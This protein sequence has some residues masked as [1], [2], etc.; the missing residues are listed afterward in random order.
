MKGSCD[1]AARR[2]SD[3]EPYGVYFLRLLDIPTKGTLLVENVP[4]LGKK[5]INKID[6]VS[7]E[8]TYV[9]PAIRGADISRWIV[10]PRFCVVVA[11]K[12]TRKE[13][14]PSEDA[15]RRTSPK[16]FAYFSQFRN[17]LLHR[18]SNIALALA[19]KTSFFAAFG[20][21]IYTFAPVKVV[22]QRMASTMKAAVVTDT[23]DLLP[24][25]VALP[26]ATTSFI[27][28]LSDELEEAY[29][30]CA[31]LNSSPAV[32]FFKSYSSA[33]RGFGSP[34]LI[35][36]LRLPRFD[37]VGVEGHTPA[38][39][40]KKCHE[41][42]STGGSTDTAEKELDDVARTIWSLSKGEMETIW[43]SLAK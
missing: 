37:S 20:V 8:D 27:P 6:P 1:Y 31:L 14:V 12:S 36:Q 40:A 16:T 39:L 7:I 4:E 28:F 29:Y 32:S 18:G 17:V 24:G 9:Y 25:K 33:G 42:S 34:S 19:E 15:L 38:S 2:G 13:Q 35:N 21:G 41:V 43:E 10:T 23:N 3:L 22:W 11:N 26:T 30:V 5:D